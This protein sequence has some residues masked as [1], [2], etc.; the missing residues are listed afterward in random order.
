M[1]LSRS[2]DTVVRNSKWRS[3]NPT[4]RRGTLA[5][6][7]TGLCNFGSDPCVVNRGEASGFQISGQ[8]CDKW[9]YSRR[10]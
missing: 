4:D 10:H 1:L 8:F 5:N 6:G 7:Q 3:G 2:V 9:P